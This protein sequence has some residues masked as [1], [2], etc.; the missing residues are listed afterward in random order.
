MASDSLRS[1]LVAGQAAPFQAS[2]TVVAAKRIAK[3]NVPV[4]ITGETGVGKEEIAKLGRFSNDRSEEPFLPINCAGLTE[5]LFESAL[6]SHEKGAF[7]D[8]REV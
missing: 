8:V 1:P 4:F 5:T 2:D 3:Y 7:A 6:F